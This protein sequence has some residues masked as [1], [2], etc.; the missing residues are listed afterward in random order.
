M[1]R[2]KLH[3]H[4]NLPIVID[5]TGPDGNAFALMGYAKRFSRDLGKDDK[6]LLKSMQSGD[7]ENLIKV[8]DDAFGDFVILER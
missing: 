1:I 3:K 8:F 4:Q 6:S 7:Y 2:E 5:L